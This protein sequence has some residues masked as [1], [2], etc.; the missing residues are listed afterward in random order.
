MK[1]NSSWYAHLQKSLEDQ[2]TILTREKLEAEQKVKSLTDEIDQARVAL[3]DEW[4][5]HMEVNETLA[6]V[7]EEP[8][9]PRQPHS[10]EEAGKIKETMREIVAKEPDLPVI[11]KSSFHSI[12]TVSTPDLQKPPVPEHAPASPEP[13]EY[14]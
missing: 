1:R 14:S 11:V 13:Q 8:P 3:A 6:A 5:D 12:V 4:V 7:C 9:I 10:P 2:V